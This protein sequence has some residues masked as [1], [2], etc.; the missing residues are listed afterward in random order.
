MWAGHVVGEYQT[1]TKLGC[2][3]RIFDDP[4]PPFRTSQPV[5][6]AS[7]ERPALCELVRVKRAVPYLT[8]FFFSVVASFS[9]HGNSKVGGQV[10]S[11]QTA[12]KLREVELLQE[13]HTASGGARTQILAS[14][15]MLFREKVGIT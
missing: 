3:S 6:L 4:F 10:I 8:K 2:M 11:L 7:W 1:L 14:R 15:L 13:G 12:S 5:L 9:T